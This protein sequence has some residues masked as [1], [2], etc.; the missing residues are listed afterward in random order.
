[1]RTTVRLDQ[2]LL[3]ELRERAHRENTSITRL[4]NQVIRR[5]LQAH[6][7]PRRVKRFRQRVT[8]MG[9]PLINLD[10][11]LAFAAELEDEEIIRKLALGK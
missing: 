6:D 7:R 10:K 11:A 8:R 3:Q 1:M 4:I 9:R 5:G 2:D